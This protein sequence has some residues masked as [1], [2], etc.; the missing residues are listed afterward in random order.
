MN[1]NCLND[2]FIYKITIRKDANIHDND[3][4]IYVDNTELNW[5]NRIYNQN[6]HFTNKKYANNTLSKCIW[7]IRDETNESSIIK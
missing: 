1:G 4:K 3:E 6:L 5:E 7:Q 2:N